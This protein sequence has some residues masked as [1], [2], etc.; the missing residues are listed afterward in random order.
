MA[1]SYLFLLNQ[2][3]TFIFDVDGVMTDGKIIITASGDQQRIMNIKDGFAL[4]FAVKQG[5]KIAIISG[6][7]SEAIRDRFTKLGI[8]DVYLGV[9]DKIETYKELCLTYNIKDEEVL[10]M[11]DDIPDYEVMTVVGLPA[12]PKNST[13]EIKKISTYISPYNGGDG[14]VRDVLEQVLKAQNKWFDPSKINDKD[15]T[16]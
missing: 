6:G 11:G 5:Y 16:W 8:H 1:N 9:A 14:C 13:E 10:Y 2:I 3:K 4:Q 12:C 15:F 7:K